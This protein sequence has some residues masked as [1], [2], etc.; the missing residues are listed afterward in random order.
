MR[1]EDINRFNEPYPDRRT[2]LDQRFS[3]ALGADVP[4]ATKLTEEIF[5]D[6]GYSRLWNFWWAQL[7]PDHE[8]ILIS[9]YL[10]QYLSGHRRG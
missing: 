2:D 3:S 1:Q 5:S 8:R 10:Y 7:L 4:H 9:D 6:F